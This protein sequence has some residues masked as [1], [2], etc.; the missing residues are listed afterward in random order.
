MNDVAVW[1]KA[2]AEVQEGLRLLLKYDPNPRLEKMIKARPELY[3]RLLIKVLAKYSDD[4]SVIPSLRP[5]FNSGKSF[6]QQW[7]FLSSPTC[8]A[9]LKV[10]AADKITAYHKYIE[11]HEKLFSVID[12]EECFDT[13]KNLLENFKENRLITAEFDYYK[14]HGS[15]LGKHPVFKEAAKM[16]AYRK[17]SV[18]GLVKEVRRLEGAIWRIG[19]EIAKGD[20]PHLLT[21]R[22]ARK[23]RR[24]REL[25]AI[26]SMID[27]YEKSR[28]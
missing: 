12:L 27:D 20:K 11:L 17:M 13:A 25:D 10:L 28:K 9:E 1:L 7:P 26:R 19:S 22:E 24:Q 21:E 2:G 16:A 23:K 8:P 6:R 4:K 14:E 18:V 15:V 3:S 5:G